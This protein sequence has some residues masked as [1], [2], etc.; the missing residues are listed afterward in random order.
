MKQIPVFRQVMALLAVAAFAV[1][2]AV[3]AHEGHKDDMSDAEMVQMEMHEAT[4]KHEEAAGAMHDPELMAQ[5]HPS[6]DGVGER[7]TPEQALEGRRE[8]VSLG[9]RLLR[10]GAITL[11]RSE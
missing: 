5:A 4:A 9:M 1:P 2:I 11:P 8:V 10:E 7:Q 3:H 6:A